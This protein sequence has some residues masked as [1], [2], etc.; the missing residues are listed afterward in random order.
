[1]TANAIETKNLS[2][3]FDHRTKVVKDLSLQVP[4]GSIYGFLGP[5]GAGKTTTIR[6]LTGM[7]KSNADNIFFNGQSLLHHTPQLF[8]KI[9]ALIETPS[10]YLH[11]SGREN[12]RI[13]TTLRNLPA[14]RIEKVLEIVGLANTGKKKAKEYS[15]GMKQRLGIAMALLADPELLILDEPVN[16]LDPQGI[17]EIRELLKTL[18]KET[19]V[20]IFVSSHLLA[21][22]ERMCTHIGIINRGVLRYQGLL[23]DMKQ[24]ARTSGEVLFR[25]ETNESFLPQ[26]QT[27]FSSVR[28]QSPNELIFPFASPNEVAAINQQLVNMNIPVTGI[29]VRGGLEEWFMQIIEKDKTIAQ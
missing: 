10:L 24:D 4:K 11:L 21:E 1:M 23:Q 26:L 3:S 20:T 13:I 5:N 6:L 7:L 17:V 28:Q 27:V 29:Q 16:G 9:G 12:L 22:V 25:I 15:L 14:T 2:Y 18:N 8:E 19:G